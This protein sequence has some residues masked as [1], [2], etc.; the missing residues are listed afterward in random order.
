MGAVVTVVAGIETSKGT[1]LLGADSC[2]STEDESHELMFPKVWR[3]GDYVFGFCGCIRTG[4]VIRYQFQPPSLSELKTGDMDEIMPLMV[5]KFVSRL[6]IVL[7]AAHCLKESGRMRS[8]LL[9]G[10]SGLLFAVED[11][12]SVQHV[13][14]G[15]AAIGGGSSFALGSLHSTRGKAADRM[16]MALDA[17]AY[18]HPRCR[19]P[20]D[21]VEA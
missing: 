12:F 3:A 14:G 16:H 18:H 8:A 2:T 20:F 10:V 6:T 21:T 1:V 15:Y 7:E 9:V 5:N 4:Q 19:P 13:N 17:A 11:D